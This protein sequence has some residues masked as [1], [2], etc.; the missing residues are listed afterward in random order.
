MPNS[1]PTVSPIVSS[2]IGLKNFVLAELL[3]DTETAHTYGS[4]QL[5]AGAID[6]QIAPDNAEPEVQY[7]DD[8]EGDVLT[9]DP[10]VK[11]TL[12][13]ADLPLAIQEKILANQMDDNG[14]LV[15]TAGDKPP[16]FAF[17]FM[18]E[19]GNKTY[20]YVWLYKGRAAPMTEAYH[21]K[22]GKT[23]TRQTGKVELTFIKR[24]HDGRYQ[25]VADEGQN[26]FTAEKAATFLGSVYEPVFTPGP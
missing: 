12:E 1:T 13:M 15:R 2:T 8:I 7:Y 22:E 10:S 21:T 17:G 18:S 20:R 23:L 26:G 3:T 14:V 9:P 19:K 11:L 24:T 5:V 4:L 6:A 25:V 16:Y